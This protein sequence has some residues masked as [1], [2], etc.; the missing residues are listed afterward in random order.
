VDEPQVVAEIDSGPSQRGPRAGAAQEYLDN[1]S[2]PA[3]RLCVQALGSEQPRH[4]LR[5]LFLV[6]PKLVL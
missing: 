6:N 1:A 4:C 5:G 2:D 3:C